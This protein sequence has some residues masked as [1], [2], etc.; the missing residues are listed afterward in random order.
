LSVVVPTKDR[1]DKL[2]RCLDALGRAVAD[3]DEVI[4]VDSAS[5]DGS[6]LAVAERHGV[7]YVRADVPGTSLARNL[8]WQTARHDLV[9]FV[10]DDVLVEPGWADALAAALASGHDF[11]TGRIDLPPAQVDI[12]TAVSLLPDAEPRRLDG[13]TRGLLGMTANTGVRRSAL[14]AIGGFDT[15]LGPAT[16]FGGGE[17][18]DFF[19]RLVHAGFTGQYDPD[20]CVCHEQWRTGRDYLAVQWSYGKGMGAR[21]AKMLMRDRHRAWAIAPEVTRIGGVRTAVADVRT[22]TGRSWRPAIVWRLGVLA[23]F[24]VGMVRLRGDHRW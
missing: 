13:T 19:D 1:A 15:R 20:V 18:N 10:D 5:V 23:G 22:R 4:V 9:G 3:G 7:R 2:D 17:D 12:E 11:V 21:F 24:L 16:W 6:T 14:H 8:G